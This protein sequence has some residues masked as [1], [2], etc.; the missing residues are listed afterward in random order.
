MNTLVALPASAPTTSG[1]ASARHADRP[2]VREAGS[3][4]PAVVCLH[5]NASSS[6][7]WR[8]LLERLAPRHRVYA[9]DGY[10]A[11]RSP[12]W[13]T[14]RVVALEDEVALIEPVL[15]RAGAP[16]ALV[17]HSYGASVALK[18]ALTHPDRVAAL[19]LYEPTLFCL[20]DE[21][22]P[23]NPAADGIRAAVAA[24]GAALD[25]G[26]ADAAAGH[27]VDYWTGAGSW[28]A[29]PAERRAPIVASIA[30][31]RGWSQALFG[32]PARLQALR[33]I[34]CPVLLMVGSASRTSA[35]S[36][37][38][39]LARALPRV[40]VIEFDGLGHMGPIT[41]PDRVNAAI[42]DFLARESA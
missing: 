28:Q 15:E 33:T 42:A 12:A 6:S 23:G 40:Q 41:H 11:G 8:A 1:S 36:V 19:A 10:G 21:E 27:F 32:E 9:P 31:V 20:L 39:L 5:S 16:V 2:H 14:D 29:T 24:A 4:G 38:R 26:D 17:G 37:A 34:D 22:L 18:T 30:N 25:A 13:P 7:Q 35:R 3:A